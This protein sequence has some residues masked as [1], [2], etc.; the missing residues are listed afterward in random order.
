MFFAIILVLSIV[1]VSMAS[2]IELEIDKKV[3]NDVI[4]S[5]LNNPAVFEFI[6]RNLGEG[7]SFELYSLVGV[8]ITPKDAFNIV[9]GGARKMRVEVKAGESVRKKIGYFDFVYKIK[10]SNTGIQEDRLRVK[11]V[12]LKNAIHVSADN[13][14]PDSEETTVYIENRED[15]DFG[16]VEVEVSSVFFNFKETFSLPE[17]G[18]KSFAVKLDKEKS[19]T[20]VAGAYILSA[21]IK[22]GNA[23]EELESTIKFLEK[24]GII[25]KET[26]EGIIIS[27]HEIE[28]KNEGNLQTVAEITIEKNIISRLFTSFNLAPDKAERSGLTVKYTWQQE[29]RPSEALT[30]VSRT[31][32]HF[33]II[34]IIAI[35]I[36]IF[37]TK[38]YLVSDI[39][40]K[41]KIN[42]V[43]TKGGEFAL[44]VSIKVKARRFVDRISII[45]RLPPIVKL[46]ERYGTI[47]PDKVDEKNRR[48][49][50]T[51]E[52]LD[53]G[54]DR[55]FSY[56]IYSKIGVVGRFELPSAKAVYEREGKI[57][58]TRS[59]KVYFISEPKNTGR[60]KLL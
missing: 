11:I 10:G 7:D 16:E 6:I 2:A 3:I 19:K 51:L 54:E 37:F 55:M 21:D 5:E 22:V 14:N 43:K 49:Q 38:I 33:P 39:M 34:I 28:K 20:L 17:L 58:E 31:N 35:A 60:I 30:V 25:T 56:I 13:I 52:S 23:T 41:K 1:S 45:D 36:I 44:K 24:S 8:D 26:K 59:N 47:A 4:V 18:K 46:Y 27:R 32:W 9:S 12:D 53:E 40:L 15:F 42:F 29:L 50:W 57:K 48:I